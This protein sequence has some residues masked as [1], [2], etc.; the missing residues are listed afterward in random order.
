MSLPTTDQL[1][2]RAA[3]LLTECG[4]A[5]GDGDQPARTP[6]TGG[7]LGAA[8][9]AWHQL[10][11]RERITS[12]SDAMSG[13][14]LGPA[15]SSEDISTQLNKF[16]A[17]FRRLGDDRLFKYLA[18]LLDGGNVVGWFSCGYHIHASSC[19]FQVLHL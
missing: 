16:G 4:A 13:S 5:A 15:Y 2:E 8:A 9:L 14:F 1:R 19:N 3:A 10:E 17:V 18:E 12:A 11:G 6:I 7:S